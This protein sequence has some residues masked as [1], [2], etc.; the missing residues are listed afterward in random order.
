[1]S[2]DKELIRRGVIVPVFKTNQRNNLTFTFKGKY[3]LNYINARSKARSLNLGSANE[4]KKYCYLN[5]TLPYG[6]PESPEIVYR[7]NGWKN[8]NDWLGIRII[9]KLK[10]RRK[11]RKIKAKRKIIKSKA[12]NSVKN[13]KFSKLISKRLPRAQNAIKLVGNLSRRSSYKYTDEEAQSIIKS[14]SKAMRE[15]RKK[16]K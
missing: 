10:R 2:I 11:K 12:I 14:L 8:F 15:L 3:Y 13:Y 5:D 16:F 4:W 1:M 7:N 6:V 9:K